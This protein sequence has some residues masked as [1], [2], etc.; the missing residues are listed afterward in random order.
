MSSWIKKHILPLISQNPKTIIVIRHGHREAHKPG[1]FGNDLALTLKG[2]HAS[3]GFGEIMLKTPIGEVHTSPVLRCVQTTEEFLKGA[4]QK[5]DVVTSENLGNPGPFI[6]DAI[7]AGPLFLQTPLRQIAQAIV[8]QKKLPGMRSL[9]EGGHLFL[10]YIS[11]VKN[12]PCVMISH[13]IIICLLCCFL[14]ESADVDKYTPDFLDGFGISIYPD[15]LL[16]H[17]QHQTRCFN[18]SSSF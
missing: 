12:F 15:F 4:S 16:I 3:S 2:R 14:F 17:H 9:I 5:V 13:D 18:V 10:S 6:T 7:K 11:Q 8:S 1:S